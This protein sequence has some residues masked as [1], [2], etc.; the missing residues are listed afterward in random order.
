[1]IDNSYTT[2]LFY[3]QYLYKLVITNSLASIFRNNNLAYAR[4]QLDRIQLDYESNSVLR[5]T[6]Y[7]RNIA[8]TKQEF[9][10][11]KILLSELDIRDD[12]K[13]RIENPNMSI[14]SN[15]KQWIKTLIAK[16]LVTKEFWE[17]KL[18]TTDLLVK[19][20][21]II[22]DESFGFKYKITLKDRIDSQFYNWLIANP[23]KVKIGAT[24]LQSIKNSNYVRGFYMY[25]KD[26]KILQLITLMIG[27]S[28]ARIDNL[29]Y[30]AINDK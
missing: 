6:M 25:I 24:C 1:M 20:N 14:Y 4:G 13:I 22:T 12:Y 10:A 2:K 16:P 11:A 21:I 18:G 29:V 5:L 9:V 17:P 30:P 19:N 7:S 28:I 27:T 15:N 3:D 26:E 8:I 23:N